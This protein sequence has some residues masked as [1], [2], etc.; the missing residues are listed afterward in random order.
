M[1]NINKEMKLVYRS[2]GEQSKY[3]YKR[4]QTGVW[5]SSFIALF[6]PCCYTKPIETPVISFLTMTPDILRKLGEEIWRIIFIF[7][8]ILPDE[9]RARHRSRI[10]RCQEVAAVV[11]NL[12]TVTIIHLLVNY[13]GLGYMH[14]ILEN[15]QFN[16]CCLVLLVQ[17]ISYQ[18]SELNILLCVEAVFS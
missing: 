11:L 15:R 10:V 9:I 12:S 17:G 7:Y 8:L 2:R 13:S 6:M 3:K 1:K 14:N 5:I 18:Q 4:L 16:I